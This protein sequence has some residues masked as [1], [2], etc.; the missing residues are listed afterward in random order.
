MS[1]DL[2]LKLNVNIPVLP[3]F[4]VPA[5]VTPK[6]EWSADQHALKI[7]IR[8][9]QNA[10]TGQNEYAV[11]LI[12]TL[13]YNVALIGLEPVTEAFVRPQTVVT[14]MAFTCHGSCHIDQPIGTYASVADIQ[15]LNIGNLSVTSTLEDTW[16]VDGDGNAVT[17]N[18]AD[19]DSINQA[20][21][22]SS[23]NGTPKNHNVIYGTQDVTI[24]YNP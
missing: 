24:S 1:V 10:S 18:I 6:W 14:P 4:A 5:G 16:T 20:L 11:E 12:G 7:Y 13:Y 22:S 2:N 15:Q 23:S 21:Q 19:A 8:E 9:Q 3:G 17:V